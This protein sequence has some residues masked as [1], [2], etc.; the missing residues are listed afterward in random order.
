MAG[1][2]GK[3]MAVLSKEEY[4]E[5]LSKRLGDDTSDEAMKDIEDFTDTYNSITQRAVGDT[6]EYQRGYQDS[7]EKWKK[8]YKA[9]FFSSGGNVNMPIDDSDYEESQD[10]K[11]LKKATTIHINDLFK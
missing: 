7:E 8:R 3:V 2:K 10:E 9:R 11:E 1:E 5:R 6:E 4:F